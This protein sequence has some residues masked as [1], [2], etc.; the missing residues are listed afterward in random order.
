MR[1]KDHDESVPKPMVHI[2]YRP[3]LWHLMRYY[4][5][6]GH[7]DF[8]LCLGHRADAIKRYF[9]SYDE[10]LSNDFVLSQ[11]G[12][13]LRLF[14]SDIQD[15]RITF[16]DTGVDT[17]IGQRLK[18]VE[19]YLDGEEAFLANYADGLSDLPLDRQIEHFRAQDKVASFACVAPNLSYHL[20]NTGPDGLVTEIRDM[21]RSAVRIN[22]GFFVFKRDIFRYLGAGEDLVEEP[23]RRL[24]A[25]RQLVAYPYDGFWVSM[26]TFKDKQRL[27]E[28]YA[29]GTAP[30]EAWK[31][32]ATQPRPTTTP[33]R[34]GDPPEKIDWVEA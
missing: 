28:I 17:S 10:C 25:E 7:K 3:L 6:H 1:V 29:R 13:E 20:V 8:V 18:A 11:G 24:V 12:R 34:S 30:W 21:S 32:A 9:L 5:H 33:P 31:H 4:A 2:G 16:A 22:G 19:S 27:D 26:D 15:W 14:S 23:F